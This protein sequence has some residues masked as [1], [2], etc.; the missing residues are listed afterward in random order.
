MTS[1]SLPTSSNADTPLKLDRV[2]WMI[3]I[4]FVV[5]ILA[6]LW[7]LTQWL[8]DT[9]NWQVLTILIVI[10][11]M[12]GILVA[13]Y[14][15]IRKGRSPLKWTWAV[16]GSL[17]LITLI[18]PTMIAGLG[19]VIAVSMM[20]TIS[21]SGVVSLPQRQMGWSLVLG[22]IT[23]L[24]AMLLDLA[25]PVDYRMQGPDVGQTTMVI[26]LFTVSLY[27]IF[28]LYQ[29]MQYTLRTKLVVSFLIVS[30]VPVGLVA[31]LN[32]RATQ[33]AL[34]DKASQSLLSA[35]QQTAADLD[36][37][38]RVNL[39]AIR[40]EAKSDILQEYLSLPKEER[41]G[42]PAAE[43][44][45]DLLQSLRRKDP[46]FIQEYILMDTEG[47]VELVYTP[48]G[49]PPSVEVGEDVSDNNYFALARAVD[50]PYIS[51]VQFTENTGDPSL[52]FAGQV[53]TQEG[54][55]LGVLAVR[56]SA[57]VLQSLLVPSN[58]LA[59]PESFGI[60]F[61]NFFIRLAH[62]TDPNNLYKSLM[63]LDDGEVANLQAANRLP[64][65][66]VEELSLDLPDLHQAMS[67]ALE[68]SS[69]VARDISTGD[70]LNEIAVAT[71]QYQGWMIAFLQP[72]S[73]FLAPVQS[74]N[75][76][77]ALLAIVVVIVV[78]GTAILIGQL[79]TTP[80]TQLAQT[81]GQFTAGN[82]GARAEVKSRD[83]TGVL[84]KSFNAMAEQVSSL[85]I[86]LEERTYQLEEEVIERE[87][88]AL[89]LY[90]AKE[91]AEAANQAK[92]VFLANMS[93]ELRTPLNAII[94]YSEMLV[95]DVEDL[96]V[97]QLKPD[98]DRIQSA[99][100]HLL[101]LINNILDLSK[102]EAGKTDLYLEAF[103]V[104]TMLNQVVATIQPVM[105]KRFNS[106]ETHY[107]SGLGQMYSDLTK[108]RQVLFNLLSNASKFTEEG[109]ISL[110]AM[111]ETDPDDQADWLTF[112]VAD[113]GI[114]MTPEQVESLFQPFTQG[115]ASTTRKYGGTGLGLAISQ[116]FCQMMGGD[117]EVASAP[118]SGTSFTVRLPAQVPGSEG[119]SKMQ[120]IVPTSFLP[121]EDKLTPTSLVA[122]TVLV[123]DDDPSGRSLISRALAKDGFRVETASSG[124]EGIQLAKAL[125]P[126]VITLDVLMPGMDGWTVLAAL[127]DDPDLANIPVI[128]VT[129]IDN[130]NM[131]IALGASDY[132]IKPVDYKRLIATANKYRPHATG[133]P[134]TV[135]LIEDEEDI[136]EML[137]R[138]LDKDNW[139]VMQ[140]QNGRVGLRRLN[141]ETPD[142]ILLDLTMP[143]MDGF[144]FVAEIRRRPRWHTIP[145]VVI[146]AK[147]LT[148]EDHA[149]LSG[150]VKH[151]VQKGDYD[152]EILLQEIRKLA[153]GYVHL[154]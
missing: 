82:L 69:F 4:R 48:I 77:N 132:L 102:I 84:A 108:L 128:M 39:L 65:G 51:Q 103:E 80:L 26:M 22:T 31:Y 44:A 126:Q 3:R 88:T 81:V 35:A 114:G 30:L 29:A 136:R 25:L 42:S 67:T 47:V 7:V 2:Y 38:I 73:A 50:S 57:D 85:L 71:M 46:I 8:E 87:R 79:L 23:A 16:I 135:L 113:T 1:S 62:G 89:E 63:P 143:E 124:H 74:Q 24:V 104:Q 98:L 66:T 78:I 148:L 49:T 93:H 14:R 75:Q 140:A 141:E 119:K 37:F 10:M 33:D 139:R 146:T 64:H 58:D 9:K 123:I 133:S 43:K 32:N 150:Y 68:D 19:A 76:T 117:I 83:E 138:M 107:E 131:G 27:G 130:K 115:D 15:A 17:M 59:G 149:R 92:S 112:V 41:E 72:Q 100:K 147:T 127:K 53:T 152:R 144:E 101:G 120:A 109:T 11:V 96:G 118:N 55:Y 70:E 13:S 122:A 111:R 125:R 106:F 99:G 45:L 121:A 52:Y 5:D 142:L 153:V 145:I 91:D 105:A 110:V 61:D 134:G 36:N 54:L 116:R 18:L 154:S 97:G 20:I 90:K 94:G 86:N 129:M 28:V 60:V 137:A 56:Y 12:I 151:V 95:E 34:I 6:A 21:L 40:T